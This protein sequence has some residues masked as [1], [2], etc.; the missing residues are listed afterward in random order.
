MSDSAGLFESVRQSVMARLIGA[1]PELVDQE[2]RNVVQEFLHD[3]TLWRQVFSF[4]LVV[5][6]TDYA[7]N[8]E[9]WESGS[10]LVEAQ[11]DGRRI[12]HGMTD[13]P[14]TA[15]GGPRAV[16]LVTD[17][18]LRVYPIPGDGYTGTMDVVVALTLLPTGTA[19]PPDCIRPYHDIIMDGVLARMYLMPDK[20]WTNLR[21]ADP[22]T[23]RFEA[24]KS[25]VR[26]ENQGGRTFG[27]VF[28][29]IIPF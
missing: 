9:D 3:T 29:K 20:P 1:T 28:M 6:T 8:M 11:Y 23:K 18:M 27:A 22:A 5:G 25:R 2:S 13:L 17:R 21:L 14:I 7:L 19:T 24:G 26:R 16:A 4:P 12:A 10:L 15:R